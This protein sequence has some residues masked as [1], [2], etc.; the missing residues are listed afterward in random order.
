MRIVLTVLSCLVAGAAI[1]WGQTVLPE[2]LSPLA[3][4]ATPV[5][6]LAVA[7]SLAGWRLRG[8]I[9]MGAL[10]GPLAMAGYYATSHLRGFGVSTSYVLLWCTAGVVVGAASGAAAWLLRQP[11]DRHGWLRGAAAGLLPGIVAGEALH[12][13]VRIADTTP[14][15]YWWTQLALGLA[16][17]AALA[18]VR[19]AGIGARVAA[20]ATAVTV[21]TAVFVAFG[22]A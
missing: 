12:G 19:L 2:S 9:A 1:S 16:L 5:M 14:V 17:L 4:S 8:A 22:L 3:N 10:A 15:A 13:L 20:V 18:G 11:G 6:L 7:A 21:A